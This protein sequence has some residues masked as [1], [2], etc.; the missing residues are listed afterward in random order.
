MIRRDMTDH[1]GQPAWLLITQPQHAELAANLAAAWNLH[2]VP[3]ELRSEL[4]WTVAH[5]DD[6]WQLW[7]Q[8][9]GL[10]AR[11]RPLDFL[12]MPVEDSNP[13]WARSITQAREHAPLAG[14]LV[15]F[16][17]LALRS[18][19]TSADHPE[20]TRFAATYEPQS[21]RD[22]QAAR[23]QWG[24]ALSDPVVDCLRRYVRRFDLL[25]LTLCC[26]PLGDRGEFELAPGWGLRGQA[27]GA[28][29]LSIVP[30]PLHHDLLHLT[31]QAQRVPARAYRDA[32]DLKQ[33]RQFHPLHWTLSRP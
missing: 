23:R 18:A 32:Q 27:S 2:D 14:Y 3:K 33:A 21:L 12:E 4:I 1:T 31:I 24:P 17:F 9:P 16:H 11:G 10:D 25:S 26:R 22:L 5:H 15:A 13:I 19:S 6:G 30:W 7:E 20:A 29:K 8:Q 28:E